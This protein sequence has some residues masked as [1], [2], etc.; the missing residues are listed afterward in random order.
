MSTKELRRLHSRPPHLSVDESSTH[1]PNSA[2]TRL[3]RFLGSGRMT[4]YPEVMVT[5]SRSSETPSTRDRHF[6]IHIQPHNSPQSLHVLRTKIDS[7]KPSKC[8]YKRT[9]IPTEPRIHDKTPQ[10]TTNPEDHLFPQLI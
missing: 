8:Q 4:G 2:D 5:K 7:A 10:L 3:S 1:S 6:Y 9:I